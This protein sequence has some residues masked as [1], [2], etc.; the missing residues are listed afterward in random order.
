LQKW[1]RFWLN[2]GGLGPLYQAES[3]I[4]QDLMPA[5]NINALGWQGFGEALVNS[6]VPPVWT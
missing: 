2:L 6:A 5:I 1:T 3:S 4:N